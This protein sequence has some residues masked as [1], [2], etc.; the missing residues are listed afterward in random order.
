MML[1]SEQ[2]G[3]LFIEVY[4]Y[5]LSVN[6]SFVDRSANLNSVFKLRSSN[7]VEHSTLLFYM[8]DLWEKHVHRAHGYSSSDYIAALN[9]ADFVWTNN[10]FLFW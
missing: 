3:F 10:R 6:C 4:E 2:N 1:T 7:N 8:Y 9:F 5:L